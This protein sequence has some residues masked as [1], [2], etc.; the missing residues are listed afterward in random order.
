MQLLERQLKPGTVGLNDQQPEARGCQWLVL[1]VVKWARLD[2]IRQQAQ[3][4]C[5]GADFRET[6]SFRLLWLPVYFQ[7]FL[8]T[9][10][11]PYFS[12]IVFVTPLTHHVKL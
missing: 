12:S 4:G 9:H 10:I 8:A 11:Q 6:G 2:V 7:V 3:Q 5:T 1:E